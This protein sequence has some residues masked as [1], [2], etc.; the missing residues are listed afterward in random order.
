MCLRQFYDVRHEVAA[1]EA[2]L[3]D[4]RRFWVLSVA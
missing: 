2:V 1:S 4:L 3:R